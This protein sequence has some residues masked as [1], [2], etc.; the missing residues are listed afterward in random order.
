[1]PSATSQKKTSADIPSCRQKEIKEI[2]KMKAELKK[3]KAKLAT[4][5]SKGRKAKKEHKE[6]VRV[7]KD[8]KESIDLIVLSLNMSMNIKS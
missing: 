5:K 4:E 3:V 7:L 2:K 8:E 1:M 6:T